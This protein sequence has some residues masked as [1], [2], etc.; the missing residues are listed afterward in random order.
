MSEDAKGYSRHR[1][2]LEE[3]ERLSITGVT[4][5]IAFDEES[6]TADTDMGILIIRGE[7]IHIGKLNLDEGLLQTEGEI[8]S[9]EYTDG[10]G[11]AKGR[12]FLFG[13]IFK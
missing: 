6:I 10:D 1:I 9:I 4:E 8:E 13:K 5:V 11:S 2:V 7:G 3:R 12:G